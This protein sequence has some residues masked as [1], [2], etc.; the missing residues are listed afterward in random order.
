MTAPRKRFFFNL[1]DRRNRNVEIDRTALN[2][3]EGGGAT[4]RVRLFEPP[5][6]GQ[7]VAV[8]VTSAD[9]AA[10][11]VTAGAALT[12]N[13]DNYRV[14]RSVTVMAPTD[15]DAIN[16]VVAITFAATGGG[17][18]ASARSTVTVL[19]QNNPGAVASDNSL[20]FAIG[21]LTRRVGVRLNTQPSGNVTAR[22]AISG[23]NRF[24][25]SPATRTFT[26][27][28]WNREQF[29]DISVADGTNVSGTVTISF[30]GADYGGVADIV[31]P[32][33]FVAAARAL[34]VSPRSLTIGEAGRGTV[35]VSLSQPPIPGQTTTVNVSSNDNSAARPSPGRLTFTEDDYDTEKNV[36]ILG[37]ND[38][39][40]ANE[41]V[42]VAFAASGGGY[43]DSVAVAVSV[44][45]DDTPGL[46][47]SDTSLA[48]NSATLRRT[49]G[50]RLGTQPTGDVTVNVTDNSARF[51]ASPAALRFTRGNHG[52]Q[53]IVTVEATDGASANASL[54]LDPQGADYNAVAS[55][56][57]A[58]SFTLRVP[59]NITGLS[60]RSEYVSGNTQ[61]RVSATWTADPLAATY[62]L[63]YRKST[64]SNW[65]TVTG[66]TATTYAVTGAD[67][68]STYQIEVQGVNASGSS[69]AWTRTTVT[70]G[71]QF[72]MYL[73]ER[74]EF[75]SINL[76]TG[77]FTRIGT[78]NPDGN[79][80][81]VE[82]GGT[83]YLVTA[84]EFGSINLSTGVFTQI[85]T[86]NPF[87]DPAML[88][89][90]GTVYLCDEQ[91]FGSINLS[92]GAFTRIGTFRPF[93]RVSMVEVGGTVYLCDEQ[94]F[95]S[96]NLSTGAFTRIGTFRPF[97][98]TTMVEVGGTVYLA[99]TL[100]FGSINLSTGA[101]TRIGTFNPSVAAFIV[102]A[103]GTVYLAD[104]DE[105]GS[106]NLST[107]VFTRIGTFNPFGIPN[108]LFTNA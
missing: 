59:A 60:A 13:R 72:I 33:S 96:I 106:I 47:L 18:N 35:A 37:V 38:A 98:R 86:F 99:D 36:T 107:G 101:F 82:A 11:R 39:D 4:I 1:N 41:N 71:G 85:G 103:G 54:T 53:Q 69:P 14:W 22:A 94:K 89:V 50:V 75:G 78:F 90:G 28:N 104:S 76:S 102:E 73:V 17:Y 100:K 83:V 84:D 56:V 30:S 93:N 55:R 61:Q 81:M 21:A 23:S 91:K 12:F 27:A 64:E 29:F 20:S 3:T 62:T 77:A 79:A 95:G 40:T 97:N 31:I 34:I 88:E 24:S 43:S 52:T 6:S 9:A 15:A 49:L 10:V 42:S 74:D 63:R 8:A 25:A 32:L 7:T 108:L 58:L 105:F 44:T 45:D 65:T 19:D 46:V 68:D 57:V 80:F 26:R 87:G 48:F 66:I 67:P 5:L 92:T 16:E 51:S 2:V 70:T